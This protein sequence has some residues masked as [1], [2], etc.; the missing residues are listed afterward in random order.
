MT[1]PGG[2]VI[3]ARDGSE[4]GS[5]RSPLRWDLSP[6]EIRTM[7]DGLI[8][9]MKKIHDDIGSLSVEHV[10][11]EN[12][13]KALAN[14]KLDYVC[15]SLKDQSCVFTVWSQP[16]QRPQGELHFLVLY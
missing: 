8:A 13:L 9:R 4:T 12:T 14:A 10:S 16:P 1:I 15:K 5:Q 7:T 6:E 2:S 11:V 3:S